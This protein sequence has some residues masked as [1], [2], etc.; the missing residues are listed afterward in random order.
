MA[1]KSILLALV[2]I[3][4]LCSQSYAQ[5]CLTPET[6]QSLLEARH[7]SA[8][9]AYDLRG[10]EAK[11]F[12]DAFNSHPPPTSLAADRAQIYRHPARPDLLVLYRGGC[13]VARAHFPRGLTESLLNEG[14]I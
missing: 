9:L 6:Y 4:C 11:A 8:A 13:F 12:V 14:G 1:R 10:Q 5:A 3:L 2:V 7:P